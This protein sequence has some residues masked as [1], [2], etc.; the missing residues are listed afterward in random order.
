MALQKIRQ[1]Y[2]IQGFVQ[3]SIISSVF[4]ELFF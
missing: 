1:N 2:D 4:V 3:K